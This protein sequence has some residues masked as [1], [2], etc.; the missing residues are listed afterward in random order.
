VTND[1]SHESGDSYEEITA[2]DDALRSL[3]RR[4]ATRRVLVGAGLFVL[5][6]VVLQLA[7]PCFKPLGLAEG[8]LVQQSSESGATIVWW[9]THPVATTFSYRSADGAMNQL[10]V[11][12]D[13][14]HHR[15][16]LSGLSA[17]SSYDY[18]I[19]IRDRSYPF[20]LQTARSA[21]SDFSFVVFGDSGDATRAQ[22]LVSREMEKLMPD[23]LVHTGDLIYPDG[24]RDRYAEK[25]FSVYAHMISRVTFWPSLG[26]HDV[27]DGFQNDAYRAVFELPENGPTGLPAEDNYWFDYAGARFVVAD[28]N[29]QEG[30]LAEQIAPW[31]ESVLSASGPQWKFVV[32]HHPPF[33]SGKYGPTDRIQNTLVP[34]FDRTGVDMVFSGHDHMYERTH[35]IRGAA[36]VGDGQGVVY[37]VSGAGGATLYKEKTPGKRPDWLAVLR[38][39]IHSFSHIQIRGTQLHFRQIDKSGTVIDEWTLEKGAPGGG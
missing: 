32:F 7:G 14:K 1:A 19:G 11:E 18:Q 20:R 3:R 36:V 21:G 9:T 24:R 2:E 29:V 4:T 30:V 15:V 26:N 25:F 37:I 17:A 13:G 5:L 6:G 35:P 8:P 38:D 22:T 16:R 33:T 28:S 34:V 31:M 12:T 39:D 27:D 10:P 23:L